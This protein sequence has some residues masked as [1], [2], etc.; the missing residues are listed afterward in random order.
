MTLPDVDP[1]KRGAVLNYLVAIT[2]DPNAWEEFRSKITEIK[3]LALGTSQ[4]ADSAS[5]LSDVE[6]AGKEFVIQHAQQVTGQ[7]IDP[8]VVAE[9][10]S[11][12][13]DRF[14]A[15]VDDWTDSQGAIDRERWI[16]VCQIVT[17]L[18]SS[19]VQ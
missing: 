7:T 6:R 4:A 16:S 11:D 13:C 2:L 17:E 12:Y 14:F 3:D 15:G 18:T 5:R 8:G 19:T 10:A 9:I 1:E